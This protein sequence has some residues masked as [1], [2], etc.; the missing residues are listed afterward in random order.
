MEIDQSGVGNALPSVPSHESTTGRS[1][2]NNVLSFPSPPVPA[3]KRGKCLTRRTGQNPKVRVGKRANGQKYFFFQYWADIPGQEERQRRTE[4]VGLL[5]QLT[6]SEAERKKV[7]FIQKLGINSDDYQIPCSQTFADAVKHYRENFAPKRLRPSTFSTGNA[8]IKTH[9]EKDWKD[10]PIEHI[11]V[12][13]VNEWASGKR[14]AGVSWT[15][16]KDSLRT[17]QRV[18]SAFSKDKKPPFSLAALEIPER[19][20]LEMRIKSRRRVSYSWKQAEQITAHLRSMDSLGAARSEQ[21]ATIILLAAASGLRCSELLALKLNDLDF[22]ASMIRVDEAS[23]QRNAGSIGQCKNA[24]AY[25]YVVLLDTE[26]R[27]AMQ[28]LKRF[29]EN[30][31][32]PNMLVFRSKRGGPLLETTILN[33]G[34]HPALRALG[35]ER[36]GMHAFRRGCNRRWELAGINPAVIRQQMGHSSA[37]MTRLYTGEI[38]PEDVA[39]AFSIRL[40]KMENEVAA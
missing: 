17:M 31:S 11:R 27:K 38:P 21:Y 3:R 14:D 19:D 22:S 37:T 33:Q 24:A 18:L 32:E 40:E 30:L 5:G 35:V 7:N 10:V 20:K 34:L 15:S 28:A 9:L 25:R 6:R 12:D 36:A 1:G 13:A 23:D 8:R 2:W 26:G 29:I 4:V 16:I 39:S